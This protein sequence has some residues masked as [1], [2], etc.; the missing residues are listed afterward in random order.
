MTNHGTTRQYG[1]SPENA[2]AKN[3]LLLGTNNTNNWKIYKQLH[4]KVNNMKKHAKQM[5]FNNL[6]FNVSD[7]RSANSREYWK[8]C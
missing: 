7:L 5:F 6:E 3:K 2:I 4:N 8:N 1:E